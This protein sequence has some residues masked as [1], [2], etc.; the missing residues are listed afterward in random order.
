MHPN[1]FTMK[2]KWTSENRDRLN[3]NAREL[4]RKNR[5]WAV[6]QLG[7]KCVDCGCTDNLEFDHITPDYKERNVCHY[8]SSI[9]RLTEEI[10]KCELRCRQCHRAR[11][12]KQL[13]LAWHLLKSV[14]VSLQSQWLDHHPDY[15]HLQQLWRTI[16]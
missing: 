9:N 13:S 6:D 3:K 10:K 5:E 16:Q 15:T 11:S 2:Q 4:K 7:G 1:D 12:D 14:P 8:L